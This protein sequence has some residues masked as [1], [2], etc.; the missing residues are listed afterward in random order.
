[1]E[2]SE[3]DSASDI[4]LFPERCLSFKIMFYEIRVKVYQGGGGTLLTTIF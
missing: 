1:M 2:G 3:F 4:V